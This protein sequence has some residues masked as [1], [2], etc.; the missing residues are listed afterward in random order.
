MLDCRATLF[1]EWLADA[2][3][4]GTSLRLLEE[5]RH[6]IYLM[7]KENTQLAQAKTYSTECLISSHNAKRRQ[8]CCL[9]HCSPENLSRVLSENYQARI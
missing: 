1:P 7:L 4:H 3:N 2:L 8:I 5:Y 6:I 9:I